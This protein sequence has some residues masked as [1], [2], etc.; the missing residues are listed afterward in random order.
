MSYSRRGSEAL[1]LILDKDY[2]VVH[3][4]SLALLSLTSKKSKAPGVIAKYFRLP[5]M[6]C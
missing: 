1:L 4:T 2:I 5:F 6:V 3:M